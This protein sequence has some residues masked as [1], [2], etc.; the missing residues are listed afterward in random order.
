MGIFF[1]IGWGVASNIDHL[2]LNL[3]PGDIFKNTNGL[4]TTP[5]STENISQYKTSNNEASS[6]DNS[7]NSGQISSSE[8]QS[9]ADQY[10]EDPNASTGTPKTVYIANKKTYVVP[11]VED[12][13]N[14]GEIQIDPK[15]GEN[16]GGAGGAP[17][18]PV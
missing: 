2:P 1:F 9:N 8:A 13:K 3:I 7:P 5:Q 14:V 10:I 18:S 17:N 12:N 6:S 11:V 16:V 15:T 4:N